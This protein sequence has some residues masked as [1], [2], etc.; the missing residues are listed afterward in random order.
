MSNLEHLIENGIKLLEG[1]QDM[2]VNEWFKVMDQ[3]RNWLGQENIYITDLWTIC[4]YIV[5][6][7]KPELLLREKEK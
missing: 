3:D 4:Q 2:D 6:Q 1:N 7:Y 5:Y